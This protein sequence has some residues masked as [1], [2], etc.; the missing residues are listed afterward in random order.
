[1]KAPAS[2]RNHVAENTSAA[3]TQLPD[4][5]RHGAGLNS[6]G[7]NTKS[8]LFKFTILSIS[9]ILVTGTSISP[10]LPY[11]AKTL[12]VHSDSSINLL[13]TV[14]Q[15][16]VL[17]FLVLSPAISKKI[18][19][20]K[21]IILGLCCIAASGIGPM[22][23]NSYWLILVSRMLLGAGM[24]MFNSLAITIINRFYDD[25]EESRMLGYRG[26]CEQVG[27][28]V[29]TLLVGFLLTFGWHSAFLIY[30]LAIP[31]AL[32]FWKVIPELPEPEEPKKSEQRRDNIATYFTPGT[33]ALFFL[34][35]VIVMVNIMVLLQIPRLA[36]AQHIM[37]A[38]DSSIAVSIATLGGFLGGVAYGRIYGKLRGYTLPAFLALYVVG[39]VMLFFAANS[40]MLIAGSLVAGF[41]AATTICG[42]NMIVLLVPPKAQAG[43]N[44]LLLVGCNIG[45]FLSTYGI[46]LSQKVM[47]STATAPIA[48][49]AIVLAVIAMVSVVAVNRSKVKF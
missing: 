20:K 4:A 48:F 46:A 47:G 31:I 42:F 12:G 21:A 43:A 3:T 5:S 19:I 34:V 23:S 11:M 35:F 9:L 32:L 24:G 28:T 25:E 26:A 45:S 33:M 7:L 16:F 37:S 27:A 39:L 13:A 30:M 36:I 8:P 40:A 18:G 44:T 14:P 6:T 2:S 41:C 17:I 38:Q 22:L 49:F 15:V 10:A 1:M 29:A